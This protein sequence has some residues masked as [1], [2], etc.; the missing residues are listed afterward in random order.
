MAVWNAVFLHEFLDGNPA[1]RRALPGELTVLPNGPGV[2][3]TPDPEDR[4]FRIAS[5]RA[6]RDQFQGTLANVIGVALSRDLV[7]SAQVGFEYLRGLSLGGGAVQ[8]VMPNAWAVQ[9][10]AHFIFMV[11]AASMDCTLRVVPS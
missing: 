9:G 8:L 2:E 10:R 7:V 6:L 1:N 3:P 11:G 4:G 5:G